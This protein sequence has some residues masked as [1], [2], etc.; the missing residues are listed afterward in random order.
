MNAESDQFVGGVTLP[1]PCPEGD[2]FRYSATRPVLHLLAEGRYD[3]FSLRELSRA[4]DHSLDNVRHAVSTLE[5]AGLVE[6]QSQ[7]NR[8]LVQIDREQL[9]VTSDPVSRI[10]QVEF[11]EPVRIALKEL[12]ERIESLHGVILFGSVAKGEADRR[13]DIDLF[14]LV[15]DQQ[16]QNQRRA[17]D[18]ADEL[19]QERIEG[20]RYRFQVMVESLESASDYGPRLREIFAEGLTLHG[21]ESLRDVRGEVLSNGR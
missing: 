12:R 17:H 3:R 19:G 8:K 6:V 14:V 1:L 18:L 5:S 9:A 21:S 2:L 20:D 16:A 15:E 11:Q 13:S 4:V 7:G 10:P